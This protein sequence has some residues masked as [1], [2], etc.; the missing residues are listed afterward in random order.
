M[1][2]LRIE[3]RRDL[4]GEVRVPGDK[5]ISHRA[6]MFGAVAEGRSRVEGFLPGADCLGTIECFRRMGVNIHRDGPTSLT[7]EGRGWEGLREPETVLDVGNS[8]TTIRLMLG[9][10][11][12]RPFH[13]TVLGDESIGRRPMNRVVEPLR[14]MGA[15]VDGRAKGLFT[16]LSVRGGNLTGITHQSQVASAQVKSSLLLAGLQGNGVTRVE[17]PALS[18]DHTERML[19]AFGVKVDRDSR[20]VSVTGGQVLQAREVRVPGDLSSAAFLLVAALIVPGSRLRIRDMGLNPTRTGILDVLRQ[21]G[22]EMEVT[23][24]GEWNGEPVGDITVSHSSLTG[25][26]VGGDLIP[27]LIDEIPVL[28]VAATQA[29]GQTVIRDAAELKV[30]ET[31]RIAATARELRKLGARVEETGDGLVIEGKT[32]LTGG[33]CDSHGDHRIGMA[34]AVAGLIAAGSTT[35]TRAEAID[36]S[37]PGFA[38][39]LGEL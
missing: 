18:R 8:G 23:Q 5:S 12:G 39:L 1:G 31:D 35:V 24:T 36:V 25:V 29:A 6:V 21:M 7:V 4:R 22:G 16:P 32:P 13:A 17:E 37:F 10:L 33:P 38:T 28:A 30:K 14:R 11:A 3:E 2:V 20:G 15:R 27:R 9:V 19:G 26:E 34:M